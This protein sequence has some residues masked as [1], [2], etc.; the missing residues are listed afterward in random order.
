MSQSTIAPDFHQ[1][2][3]IHGNRFAQVAFD[4]SIPLYDIAHPHYLILGEILYLYINIDKGF[5][6][7]LGRPA[8]SDS[9]DIGQPNLNPLIERQIDSCN[10]SQCI[11][12]WRLPRNLQKGN[13]SIAFGKSLS[14][15][16]LGPA[17]IPLCSRFLNG[18]QIPNHSS[19]EQSAKNSSRSEGNPALSLALFVLGIG[20]ANVNHTLAANHLAFAANFFDRCPYLH[21]LCSTNWPLTYTDKRFDPVSNHKAIAQQESYPPEECV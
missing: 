3:Y 2:L 18:P 19:I 11:P 10:S 14:P 9:I 12:P 5:L 7:D 17:S 16:S 20:T 6:A 21:V 4:H 13:C 8:F 15:S 1:P